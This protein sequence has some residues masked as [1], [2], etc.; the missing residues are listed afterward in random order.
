MALSIFAC[1]VYS[2]ALAASQR[3]NEISK[4]PVTGSAVKDSQ[5]A[6]EFV[7]GFL[8]N[9]EELTAQAAITSEIRDHFK[10]TA[11]T[12][13]SLQSVFKE[14]QKS[15]QASINK[16]ESRP[17]YVRTDYGALQ[18]LPGLLAENLAEKEPIFFAAGR[19]YKYEDGIYR[20][21]PE[22]EA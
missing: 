17:W 7:R 21:M 22:I 15:Y 6:E 19:Y 12:V 11:S 9:Q 10:L 8:Y 5:T 14:S 1:S 20:E 3:T 18:F 2:Q 13:K 16:A 4:L